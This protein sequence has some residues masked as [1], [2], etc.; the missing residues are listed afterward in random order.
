MPSAGVEFITG[1]G[2]HIPEF[3]TAG[4]EM[5]TNLYHGSALNAKV[6]LTDGQVKLSIPPPEGNVQLLSIRSVAD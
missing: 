5:H 1:M 2:V 3:V 4:I 6:T